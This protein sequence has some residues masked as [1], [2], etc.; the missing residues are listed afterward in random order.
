MPSKLKRIL[1]TDMQYWNGTAWAD[2]KA[3]DLSLSPEIQTTIPLK[4]DEETSTGH[5]VLLSTYSGNDIPV[6]LSGDINFEN[7][8]IDNPLNSPNC[9]LFH[10]MGNGLGDA[11]NRKTTLIKYKT[12]CIVEDSETEFPELSTDFSYFMI[13]SSFASNALVS[14][15]PSGTQLGSSFSVNLKFNFPMFQSGAG[16]QAYQAIES[17]LSEKNNWVLGLLKNGASLPYYGAPTSVVL[18][19]PSFGSGDY[20]YGYIPVTISRM[21][22]GLSSGEYTLTARFKKNDNGDTTAWMDIPAA[23]EITVQL[24]I[25]VANPDNPMIITND[26]DVSL[27]VTISTGAGS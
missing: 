23:Y 3:R 14:G 18:G 27:T 24:T 20:G 21:F 12:V 19:V 2:L 7:F 17:M 9:T 16:T 26:A 10:S 8:K 1:L 13:K 22:S 6:N 15:G 25:G 4:W 5:G 11:A